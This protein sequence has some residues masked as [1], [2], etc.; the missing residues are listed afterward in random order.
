MRNDLKIGD[1]T[2]RVTVRWPWVGAGLAAIVF[3]LWA[4]LGPGVDVEVLH[5]TG[6]AADCLVVDGIESCP[7]TTGTKILWHLEHLDRDGT[8]IWE[9]DGEG[10]T[11]VAPSR[12]A[13]WLSPRE[14]LA[15]V[16]D[17]GEQSMLDV[18][19]R[20]AAAPTQFYLRLYND[21]CAETKT[22]ATLTSEPSTNGYAA[23][24][25]ERSTTGWPSLALSGGD[26]EA[27]ASTETFSASGGSW[28]PVNAA[29]L[30]TTSDNTGKALNC[31]ALSQARTLAAGE[32]LQATLKVKQQ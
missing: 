1:K 2:Y 21:T 18:Y 3:G 10:V 23:Q 7:E 11:L 13:S 29:V 4:I 31:L 19:F 16:I 14:A 28:G 6:T 9:Q 32:Q 8:V 12:A 20:G 22:L 26:Y 17:E 5:E 24:L 25:I 15:A 27:T 30:A